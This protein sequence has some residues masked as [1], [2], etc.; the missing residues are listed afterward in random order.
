MPH[1]VRTMRPPAVVRHAQVAI[2]A[3]GA[4]DGQSRGPSCNVV[5]PLVQT[6]LGWSGSLRSTAIVAGPFLKETAMNA[7]ALTDAEV[8]GVYIQVNS[9]DIETALLGRAQ[10]SFDGGAR[11]GDSRV[12]GPPGCPAHRSISRRRA[13]TWKKVLLERHPA[14]NAAAFPLFVA[15]RDFAPFGIPRCLGFRAVRHLAPLPPCAVSTLAAASLTPM[16]TRT[17]RPPCTGL[18]DRTRRRERRESES[19]RR[20]PRA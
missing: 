16:R 8:V 12:G 14:P 7:S 3:L 1:L 19:S 4:G 20:G 11:D 6:A 5:Y 15:V 13:S 2:P 10:A 9:F 18:S 17:V